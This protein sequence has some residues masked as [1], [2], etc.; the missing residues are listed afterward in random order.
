MQK[1][2]RG[3]KKFMLISICE[4]S[5]HCPMYLR[6][7]TSW[8]PMHRRVKTP[9]GS[10][11][12]GVANFD[13]LKIQNGPM[14]HCPM[15]GVVVFCFFEPSRPCN[16]LERNTHSKNCLI[17]AITIQI[18]FIHVWKIFW[19]TPPCPKHWGVVLKVQ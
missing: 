2:F 18:H 5:P 4:L 1:N 13:P 15:N 9:Q 11:H 17:V 16:S 8:G 3:I 10:I 6:V 12:W 19:S 7:A 14:Y